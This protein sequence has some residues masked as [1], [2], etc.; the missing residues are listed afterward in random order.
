MGTNVPVDTQQG[1]ESSSELAS[2]QPKAEVPAS[3][4]PA[5]QGFLRLVTP[6]I[7][8]SSTYCSYGSQAIKV[9]RPP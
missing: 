1:E 4:G 7:H 3:T 2:L 8:R 6:Y 9:Y 5:L